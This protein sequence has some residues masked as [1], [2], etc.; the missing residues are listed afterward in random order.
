MWDPMNFQDVAILCNDL[1]GFHRVS[2]AFD[3]PWLN[4]H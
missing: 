1:M 2:P 4:N 3:N